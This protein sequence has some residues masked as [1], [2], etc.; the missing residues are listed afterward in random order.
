[1][2]PEAE[3]KYRTTLKELEDEDKDPDFFMDTLEGERF[4]MKDG[5][6]SEHTAKSRQT[7]MMVK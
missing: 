7:A 2:S 3:E 4:E 1:M 6:L 5:M